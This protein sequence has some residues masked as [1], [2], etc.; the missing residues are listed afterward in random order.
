[1]L[2]APIFQSIFLVT[3]RCHAI[4]QLMLQIFRVL[5]KFEILMMSIESFDIKGNWI[6]FLPK[7]FLNL[8]CVLVNW[9]KLS[10][11]LWEPAAWNEKLEHSFWWFFCFAYRYPSYF[12]GTI[13]TKTLMKCRWWIHSYNSRN[14]ILGNCFSSRIS[15][16]NSGHSKIETRP[17]I[18]PSDPDSSSAIKIRTL[19]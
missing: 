5:V 19:K 6:L 1:M 10:H 7:R 15:K 9:V 12:G 4:S 11:F 2:R 17:I 8:N 14:N 18:L 3:F 16:R 13:S